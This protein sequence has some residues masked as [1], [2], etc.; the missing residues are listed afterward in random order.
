[1][2]YTIEGSC[3]ATQVL[4]HYTK[5]EPDSKSTEAEVGKGHLKSEQC[6]R[7]HRRRNAQLSPSLVPLFVF[8]GPNRSLFVARPFRTIAANQLELV[9]FGLVDKTA[10]DV[11][12]TKTLVCFVSGRPVIHFSI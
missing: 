12:Q 5:T 3:V 4:R 2:S 10:T 8:G 6:C 7:N 9:L 1:M 11:D